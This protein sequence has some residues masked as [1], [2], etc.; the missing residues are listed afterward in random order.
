MMIAVVGTIHQP[1]IFEA[2]DD[3]VRSIR[4]PSGVSE[5]IGQLP[6]GW[7]VACR[8]QLSC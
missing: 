7:A 6:G 1:P 8:C 2:F 4:G 3:M 5:L